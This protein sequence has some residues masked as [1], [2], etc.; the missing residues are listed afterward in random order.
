MILSVLKT[1]QLCSSRRY[2]YFTWQNKR[3]KSFILNTEILDCAA[4]QFVFLFV[5]SVDVL[6]LIF[7]NGVSCHLKMLFF[8]LKGQRS[9]KSIKKLFN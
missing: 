9:F 3:K 4:L 7:V 5:C 2:N 6:S 1:M 8:S